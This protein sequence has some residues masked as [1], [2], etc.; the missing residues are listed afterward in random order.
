M[1]EPEI[2]LPVVTV[3]IPNYNYEKWV[4]DAINSVAIQ[5]YPIK[6]IVV[7]DDKSTDN[8]YHKVCSIINNPKNI[9]T[10]DCVGCI[11]TYLSVPITCVTLKE[12]GGPA[13]ARNFGIQL[14][15]EATHIYGFLDSDDLY[16]PGKIS[17]SV[18]IILEDP[19]IIGAVYSDYD[20]LNS[21]T[22]LRIREFKEPFSKERLVQECIV[23]NDTLV[24]KLA[25][26][27]CG[28]YCTELR[29]CEDYDLWMR[30][31]EKFAITHI[32]EGL[33][34]VRVTGEGATF[35]V[36]QEE[37]GKNWRKVMQRAQER[38][39]AQHSPS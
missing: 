13:K 4:C 38:M 20:T 29:T 19:D 30:I 15:W 36:S 3:V 10:D 33:V 16:L 39:Y 21:K 17:K 18:S 31:S 27:K 26:D 7:V 6:Q 14:A 25:L 23:N 9:E 22:G 35:S 28:L 12:N 24:T 1:P 11:G 8:S 34:I 2:K 5:D 37:W 32:P